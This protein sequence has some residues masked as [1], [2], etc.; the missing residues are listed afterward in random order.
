MPRSFVVHY[1]ALKGCLVG[2]VRFAKSCRY[3]RMKDAK[4]RMA[5]I[6]EANP[7]NVDCLITTDPRVPEIF[8]HCGDVASAIGCRCFGCGKILTRTDARA[9]IPEP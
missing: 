2:G 7:D 6:L 9:A 1:R 8:V 4:A 5:G 3:Q